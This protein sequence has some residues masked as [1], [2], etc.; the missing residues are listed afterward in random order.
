MRNLILAAFTIVL[1]VVLGALAGCIN[2]QNN[3]AGNRVETAAGDA[4]ITAR[5]IPNLENTSDPLIKARL[6]QISETLQKPIPIL[7]LNENLSE[8]QK[9]AQNLAIA[10]QRF[11]QD[12]RDPKTNQPR[13]AEIFGVYPLRA[14]DLVGVAAQQCQNSDCYR[15]EQYNFA[16]NQAASA[17]VNLP[18]SAVLSVTALPQTQ[19]DVPPHLTKLALHIAT[20]APEVAQAL[21][22]KPTDEQALM[23]NTKTALNKSRCERSK[24]LCVAPTF[25]QQ[26]RALW[27]IIDLTDLNLVGTRWTD[28][29]TTGA[30]TS[31]LTEKELQNNVLTKDFCEKT[32][33]LEKNGWAMDHIITSSDGLRVSN[34]TFK[35]K[36]V[37]RDMKLVDWHVNYSSA[38]GFGY[39]DA[40]GCPV[41]SQAAVIAVQGTRVKPLIKNNEEVGFILHQD[42]WSEG[43]P[44]PCNYYYDQ[45]YEFYNDGRFRPATANV[46]R[47]CGSDG[48]YRPVTRIALATDKANFAEWTDGAWANWTSEKWQLQ[49]PETAFTPEGYQY[50]VKNQ[51]NSG[52][53]IEPGRGQFGDNGRGD[54][55]FVY[56][57][58]KQPD[59]DE[60][61]SDLT[62][63][64]AC[65]NTDYRQGPEK[66]IEPAADSIENS[67]FVIWYV[68]QVKNDDTPGKE[69]CWAESALENG[70]Y[71]VKEYPCWSGPMI[72]PF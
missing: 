33:H 50:A 9:S 57:T 14:S 6:Q 70:V 42:Y 65:C 3:T 24:H 36:P 51:D 1:T 11:T 67:D 60:G 58:K 21:G 35:G 32:T 34:V 56:V 26:P 61:D 37:V 66:F 52:F 72:H 29:G 23:A 5:A 49:K 62:T 46:G 10:D 43:Y 45:H 41:F 38:D 53:Y 54:N 8:N 18:Q 55:A 39:S 17:I 20:N 22:F 2:S 40:V 44:T 47:G 31:P 7:P 63:I 69:Y 71:R 13:F 27:T 28:V 19:P 15:V 59:K 25:V 64:G 16:I 4:A 68:A 30:A 48:T 12:L